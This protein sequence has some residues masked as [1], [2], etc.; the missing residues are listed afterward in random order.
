[1]R[2]RLAALLAVGALL[3]LAV[4]A[5]RGTSGIPVGTPDPPPPPSARVEGLPIPDPAAISSEAVTYG[6]LILIILVAIGVLL[7]LAML[8]SAMAE[9]RVR[10]ARRSRVPEA[11]D[12]E[13]SVAGEQW[14]AKA[15]RRALSEIDQRKGGPPS[16]AVIA[17]WV[18]LEESAAATG[19]G[20][21]PHQTP[22]EFAAA[23]LADHAVDT[24]ALQ[25]LKNLYHRA[26]FGEAG[27]V[28]E[29][30]ARRARTALEKIS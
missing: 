4:L 21:E 3:L 2:V 19:I 26:R 5:A 15:T 25:D 9:I 1:M 20:R 10:R 24:E 7:G 14:L 22:S 11:L 17:A 23:V 8:L 27:T 30:D 6:A 12:S 28:T 29:D 13:P 18:R 16:D